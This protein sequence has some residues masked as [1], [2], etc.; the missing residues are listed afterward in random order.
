M[1]K[2]I[3]VPVDGS[4][5]SLHSSEVA[6]ELAVKHEGKIHL[7][8]VIRPSEYSFTGIDILDLV[9]KGAAEIIQHIADNLKD[10]AEQGNVKITSEIAFGNPASII[11]EKSK[12]GFDSIVIASRGISGLSEI[13]MGSVSNV[14]SHHAKCPVLIIR[15]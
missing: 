8:H 5:Q 13:F 10:A 6:L 12:Q 1:F 15:N 14:V 11:I 4:D 7:L 3:L 9:Q 2:N